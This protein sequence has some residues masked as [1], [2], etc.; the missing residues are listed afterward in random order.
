MPYMNIMNK[1]IYYKE[2]GSG[3]PIVFLNGMMMA[4]NSWSPFTRKLS[5]DYRTI[6]VDLL[7][8]GRSDSSEDSYNIDVQVEFLKQFLQE[9]NLEKVHLLGT[10]YGGKVA[11]SFATKY[12]S[13]IKSLILSNTDSYTTNIMN[14]I[15]KGWIYGASTLDSRIFSTLVMPYIYSYGYYEKNHEEIKSKGKAFDNI[16]DEEWYK[17]FKRGIESAKDYNVYHELK[18]IKSPTLIISSELDIITPIGYQKSIY[19][20]IGG[21]QWII[22]KGVGHASMYEKP[23]EFLSIVMKFL[24]ENF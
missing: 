1:N 21:S 20:Q 22:M 16:L 23:E 7:D 13:N 10:S 17:R 8:Q 6:T 12:P 2:Y 18:K 4:T 14:D 24:K 11:L 15:G 19:E 3:D 5:K 9:L